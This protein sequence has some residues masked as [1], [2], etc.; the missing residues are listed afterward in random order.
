MGSG[1]TLSGRGEPFATCISAGGNYAH[2][3]SYLHTY[4][5]TIKLKDGC[6]ISPYPGSQESGITR[7]LI[8]EIF[9]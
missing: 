8:F 7:L 5:Y 1:L 9:C 6:L 4:F 3:G 2:N